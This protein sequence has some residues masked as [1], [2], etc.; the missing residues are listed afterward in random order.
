MSNLFVCC[1]NMV[2]DVEVKTSGLGKLYA[3]GRVACNREKRDRQNNAITEFIN[4]IAFEEHT[5]EFMRAY[6]KKGT[7]VCLSGALH[8]DVYTN[9][10]GVTVY[11]KLLYITSADFS[12][13]QS[14]EYAILDGRLTMDPEV[15]YMNGEK[16][17]AIAR[18]SMAVNKP[19]KDGE[20]SADFFNCTVFGKTA[21]NLEKYLSKGS[22][23]SVHGELQTDEYVDKEGNKKKSIQILA[24]RIVYG[25]KKKEGLAEVGSDTPVSSTNFAADTDGFMNIPDGIQDEL[26]FN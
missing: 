6:F 8:D 7:S 5:V 10:D 24:N 19:H 2:A 26:P 25:S 17:M 12:N 15:R 20:P 16:P 4:F 21:E 13:G 18:F 14:Y 11:S 22:P 1:G 23:L 3:R 9:K